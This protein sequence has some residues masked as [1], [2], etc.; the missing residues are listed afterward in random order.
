MMAENIWREKNKKICWTIFSERY[1]LKNVNV[2]INRFIKFLFNLPPVSWIFYIPI[3]ILLVIIVVI[4]I[5]PNQASNWT[6][7]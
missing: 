2:K 6:D 4:V 3:A 5:Q 1:S 7:Q